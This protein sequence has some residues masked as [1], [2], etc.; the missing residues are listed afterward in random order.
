M[1]EEDTE[2]AGQT[3]GSTLDVSLKLIHQ[4]VQLVLKHDSTKR[5]QNQWKCFECIV[6]SQSAAVC[7]FIDPLLHL[8]KMFVSCLSL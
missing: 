2:D 6:H 7:E 5:L 1:T 4:L 3:V 8:E